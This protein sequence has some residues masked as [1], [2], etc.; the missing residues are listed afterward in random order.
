LAPAL[1]L[2]TGDVYYKDSSGNLSA[3]QERLNASRRIKHPAYQQLGL[4]PLAGDRKAEQ[5]QLVRR[6]RGWLNRQ[7]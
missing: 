5:E 2:A 6:V 3:A 7:P 1:K 4:Q